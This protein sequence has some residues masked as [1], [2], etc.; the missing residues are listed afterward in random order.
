MASGIR[1]KAHS[2]GL[3]TL[4][5][6]KARSDRLLTYILTPP[7]ISAS[8]VAQAYSGYSQDAIVEG[9]ERMLRTSSH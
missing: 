2:H 8:Y 7:D 1:L 4:S 3:L 9:D 5:Y 6:I